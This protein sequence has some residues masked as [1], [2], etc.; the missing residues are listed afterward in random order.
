MSKKLPKTH[1]DYWQSR[2][3]KRSYVSDGARVEIPAWQVRVWHLRREEWFNLETSNKAAAAI[4]ARDIYLMLKSAGWDVTLGKYKP[5]GP[6]KDRQTIDGFI[7]LFRESILTLDDAPAQITAERYISSLLIIA[8]HLKLTKL[9]DLTPEAVKRF[10]CEYVALGKKLGRAENSIKNSCN[11]VLRNAAAMFSRRLIAEYSGRGLAVKNPFEGQ[12]LRRVEIKGY[13]PLQPEVLNKIWAEAQLLRDG[14][15]S[16]PTPESSTGRWGPP[17]FKIPHPDA[18]LV[19][20]LEL[21]LGLR[22]NEADSAQWD[23]FFER[24]GRYFLEVRETQ[25]FRPKNKERRVIPVEKALHDALVA[26]RKQVSPFIVPGRL[27]KRLDDPKRAKKSR[28]YRCDRAHRVLTYWLRQR[29]ID[30]DKPCHLLRKEFGSYVAT[31]F[32][33]FHAQKMLGHSSP[34]VT[35]AFY[36]GLTNL[37]ELKHAKVG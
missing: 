6:Q 16:A 12:K 1:Q 25:F 7:Q 32:G 17:D 5:R 10:V 37:P 2:L 36:A 33:L 19:L 20:L 23:W 13:T 21:G 24:E 27:P 26:M 22:R 11:A 18:Y 4:K 35:E 8:R 34:Q 3:R 30:D 31:A 14:N 29:G 9:A 15:P 28:V